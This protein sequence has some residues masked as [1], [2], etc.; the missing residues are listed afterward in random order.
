MS[1][2]QAGGFTAAAARTLAAISG[3]ETGGTYDPTVLGDLSLQNST[4]GPSVGVFQIRTLKA[5]TGTGSVRDLQWLQ[6]SLPHQ[7]AAAYSISSGGRNW[8]PWSTFTSGKYTAYLDGAGNA[9]P[10]GLGG[11]VKGW[12]GDGLDSVTGPIVDSLQGTAITF[13]VALLGGGLVVAGIYQTF[14]AQ[15]RAGAG[16]ALKAATVL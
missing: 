8:S 2:A 14:G 9:E 4:W 7:V 13:G 15:I 3:A 6:G 10:A 16:S 11:K 5:E 12:L 1:A